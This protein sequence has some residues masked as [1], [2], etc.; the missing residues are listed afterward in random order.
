MLANLI[1]TLAISFPIFL[2]CQSKFIKLDGSST[3]FLVSEAV[4]EEFGKVQKDV[5]VTVGISGT[6]GGFQKFCAGEI[7]INNASRP[8]KKVEMEA[9]NSK[10]VQYI[11]LPVAYDAISIIVNKK[12]TWLEEITLENLKKI[13]QPQSQQTVKLWSDLNPAW[14]KEELKL[15]GAG[16]DSGTFD[17]FTEVVVGKSGSSRSDY[18]S[19]EDDNVI[20]QGVAREIYSLGYVGLAYYEQNKDKLKVVPLRL[21]E[22]ELIMPNRQNVLNGTYKFLSRPLFIYV[23]VS[24][25]KKPHV[26]DFIDFYLKNAPKLADEVGYIRLS[27]EL[28]SLAR[29]RVE[30]VVVGS[31]FEGEGYKGGKK[32]EDLYASLTPQNNP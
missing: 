27:D 19:S 2:N 22:D 8:I 21:S 15:F 31:V 24:A 23:N 28:Y 20:V 6:G 1:F 30:N 11:E 7:D 25:L 5:K 9:C 29:K 26:K 13:W 17:F 32:L 18:N 3:V 12:N 14:P 10:G 16:V 4:A